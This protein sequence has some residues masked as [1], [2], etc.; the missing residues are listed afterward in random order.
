MSAIVEPIFLVSNAS[1][2]SRLEFAQEF[3]LAR[4]TMD[5]E[6][7]SLA[8]R[9]GGGLC[10]YGGSR[11]PHNIALNFGLTINLSEELGQAEAFYWP[12]LSPFQLELSPQAPLDAYAL[13]ESRRYRR[14]GEICLWGLPLDEQNELIIRGEGEAWPAGR[15]QASVWVRVLEAA[16]GVEFDQTHTFDAYAQMPSTRLFLALMEGRAAGAAGMFVFKRTAL[17]F[18]AGVIPRYRKQ[19]LHLEL[20]KTRIEAARSLGC[21][22]A[23]A[24]TAIDS[25]AISN[26]RALGFEP[27]GQLVRYAR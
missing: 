16:F 11:S 5:P 24:E 8:Q 19:G 3:A 22:F 1:L 27:L 6:C 14:R 7:G 26:L 17:F 25:P 9:Q 2:V 15:E 18:A 21:D 10:V 20:L 13:L 12:R 4:A 23:L